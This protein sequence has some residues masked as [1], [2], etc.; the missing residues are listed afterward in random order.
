MC[1]HGGVVTHV[2]QSYTA[3]RVDGRLP[4]LMTD[5]YLVS[6]CPNAYGPM[7]P[8]LRVQWLQGSTMLIVKG[9]PALTRESV[10]LCMT[11]SGVA[12]GPAIVTYTQTGT[13]EPATFT[14][15]KD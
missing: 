15:V 10:G 1:P 13:M 8:C 3:Y 14:S 11:S 2:P 9:S 4:M 5:H 7:G 6:G 12:A